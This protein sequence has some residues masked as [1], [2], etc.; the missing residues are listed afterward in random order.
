MRFAF[1]AL[2]GLILSASALSTP[3]LAQSDGT[4][5]VGRRDIPSPDT[6]NRDTVTIGVGGLV[7]PRYEGSD[8]Y[9]VIPGGAVR[10]TLS[11]ISFSTVGT[12][13]YVN[14]L[15]AQ[16]VG[17]HFVFGP[18][19]HVTLQRSSLRQTRDPAIVALGRIPVAVEVGANVGISRT[20]VI[21]SDYD[22]LSINLGA[23]HDVTGQHDSLLLYPSIS[24]GTPL[25]R[26]AYVGVSVAAT[27][28]GG[29]YA[30]TYFGVT[31]Q[32]ALTSGLAS[33]SLG[34]GFKDVNVGLL[35]NLSVTG[36]LRRGL[37][38][39][40]IGNYSRLLGDFARS[41]VVAKRNQFFGGLGLAYTF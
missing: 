18:M 27:Y 22:N 40:A 39:F 4:S 2:A 41:P 14:V 13:L 29:G 30:R 34:D 26:K 3:A 9:T 1:A 36:D 12:A 20:G 19:A 8:D 25:S 24:Y 21:T 11:G 35:G 31:N 5:D 32:Q 38:L 33:Y 6:A 28:V 17:T 16:G 37:S 10:G 15:P 23:A 7:V